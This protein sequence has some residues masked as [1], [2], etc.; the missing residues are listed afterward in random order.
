MLSQ[1]ID[2]ES[3]HAAMKSFCMIG[4]HGAPLP[5]LFVVFNRTGLDESIMNSARVP[6]EPGVYIAFAAS[7]ECVYVGESIN[8]HKRICKTDR[9][10]LC[11]ANYIGIVL[12]DGDERMRVEKFYMGLFNPKNNRE[13]RQRR[14]GC[15]QARR[16]GD[17]KR[18]EFFRNFRPVQAWGQEDTHGH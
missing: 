17:S 14:K 13:V 9:P 12:C 5:S 18:K 7:G 10:E 3:H 16:A 4:K 11:G 1:R 15:S 6:S 2:E 8:L